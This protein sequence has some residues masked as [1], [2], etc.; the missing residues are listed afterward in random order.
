VERSIALPSSARFGDYSAVAVRGLRLAVLSQQDAKLWVASLT[1][2][3]SAATGGSVTDF[4]RSRKKHKQRY[5][6]LEGLAW[7]SD[8]RIVVVSDRATRRKF[9]G[10]A[11][12]RDESI[13]VF[14]LLE[15]R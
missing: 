10:R 7:I 5:Y 11:R 3:A 4:P 2:D 1:S 6:T 13:H 12:R 15:R 8:D 9:P 14:R